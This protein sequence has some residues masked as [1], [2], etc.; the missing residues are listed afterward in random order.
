MTQA[1]VIWINNT[2]IHK[3]PHHSLLPKTWWR[4]Q[5]QPF[6]RYWPFVRGIHR[7]PVNSPPKCQ[8]RGAFVF[9][10]ICAWTNG[11]V[12]NRNAGDLTRHR[13]H[14]DVTAMKRS[15][16]HNLCSM[17]QNA[18]WSTHIDSLIAHRQ[19][20]HQSPQWCCGRLSKFYYNWLGKSYPLTKTHIL[21]QI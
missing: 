13:D 12:R 17:P 4:H 8:W 5:M 16:F 11:W 7:S 10:L 18:Y 21:I 1:W 2:R 19:L 15:H 6:P 14:Y 20:R 9:S 3:R